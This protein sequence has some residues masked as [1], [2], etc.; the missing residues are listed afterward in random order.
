MSI[1]ELYW[2]TIALVPRVKANGLEFE[3]DTFGE[4]GGAPLLLVMGL[5]AQLISWDEGFCELLA[6]RGFRVVRF[7]NRDCGLSSS[8]DHLG[9]PSPFAVAEGSVPPPY[10][11][12]EMAED[13]AAILDALDVGAVHLVGASMGGFIAQLVAIRH[14]DRVLSLTSI[15]SA[16]GGL[17]D[18]VPA[19]PAATEALLTPPPVER[20]AMIEHGVWLS[21]RTSGPAHFDPE[22]SRRRRARAV[23]RAVNTAGTA[24]Q[25]AA[26]A[27]ARSRVEALGRLRVPA[28]VIHG[29]ADPLVPVENG[30]RTAAAIPGARL[31]LFPTMGH[32]LPE[33][34]WPEIVEAIAETAGRAAG[35][36]SRTGQVSY[37]PSQGG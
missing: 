29:E 1:P 7:D 3:Y 16:P 5:G 14:P 33:P 36:P 10:T 21:S 20:E 32:D 28:L 34:F 2:R 37:S 9:A 27:A 26:I 18:N 31:L 19:T 24:R 8:L 4:E 25:F 12:E 30:R 23:D 15:M 11:L 17:M 22:E 35:P 6:A 13:T